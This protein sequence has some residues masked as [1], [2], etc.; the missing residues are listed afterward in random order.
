[1]LADRIADI[2]AALAEGGFDGWLF[3]AFQQ[4]D[5]VSLDLLGLSGEGKLVTRRCYYLIP[6]QGSPRKYE[7][8]TIAGARTST[9][10]LVIGVRSCAALSSMGLSSLL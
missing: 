9:V 7:S 2:Q 4:N 1:M 3:A 5:P 8:K 10:R 6:R